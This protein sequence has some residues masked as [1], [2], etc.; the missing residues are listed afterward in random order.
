MLSRK[1]SDSQGLLL[2]VWPLD[3]LLLF[4]EILITAQ[5]RRKAA[6][7]SAPTASQAPSANFAEYDPVDGVTPHDDLRTRPRIKMRDLRRAAN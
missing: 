6:G 2:Y 5:A 3:A 4:R 7:G 1:T